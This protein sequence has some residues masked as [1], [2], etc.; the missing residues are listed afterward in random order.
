MNRRRKWFS[1]NRDALM[2]SMPNECGNCGSDENLDIHHIVPLSLGGS[3]LP[4]NLAVLCVRCHGKAHAHDAWEQRRQAQLAGIARAKKRGVY[5]GR[6]IDQQ[7]AESIRSALARGLSIRVTAQTVGCSTSTV[8]R[9]KR[10][11]MT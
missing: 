6:P 10:E 1:A 2:A 7:L 3:N 11:A 5:R 4:G 8:Q 9:V